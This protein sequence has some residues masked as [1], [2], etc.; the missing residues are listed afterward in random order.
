MASIKLAACRCG[1]EGDFAYEKRADGIEATYAVCKKCGIR[2]PSFI[3]NLETSAKQDAADV[4]NAGA[5][6]WPPWQQGREYYWDDQVTAPDQQ[7]NSYHWKCQTEKTKTEPR[8][9]GSG[10]WIIEPAPK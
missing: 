7:N 8:Q 9:P 10:W 3:A 5:T 4:F 2:T 1:G 6:L